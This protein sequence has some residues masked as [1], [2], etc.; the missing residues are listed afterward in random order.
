MCIHVYKNG[1]T[2]QRVCMRID[3]HVTF[4]CKLPPTK[5]LDIPKKPSMMS[6]IE[7][8]ESITI[9]RCILVRY[10][11]P[12]RKPQEQENNLCALLVSVPYGHTVHLHTIV[13][14]PSCRV[15]A[16]A[17]SNS[18]SHSKTETLICIRWFTP[19]TI[20]WCSTIS[21]ANAA[22]HNILYTPHTD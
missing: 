21:S 6:V 13:C 11:K 2:R 15:C 16:L 9:V 17:R 7:K 5:L 8:R 4:I 20:C 19:Q 10:G 3:L 22:W 12:M 14:H 18:I 1:L